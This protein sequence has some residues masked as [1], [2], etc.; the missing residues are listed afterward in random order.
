MRIILSDSNVRAILVN[1][2]GGITRCDDIANGLIQA[3]QQAD[4]KVPIVARLTGTN[5]EKARDIL[6]GSPVTPAE[7]MADA[8]KKAVMLARGAGVN[9]EVRMTNVRGG[10]R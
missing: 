5:A 2:F 7:T 1:I 8:V 10:T 9:D 6:K 4:I 3:R